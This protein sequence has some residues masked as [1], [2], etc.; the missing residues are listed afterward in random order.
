MNE[1]LTKRQRVL[2][3]KARDL[4]VKEPE[5]YDQERYG[6]GIISCDT[7]AC[8]AGH[9][10]ASEP[11]LREELLLQLEGEDLSGPDGIERIGSA[12]HLIACTALGTPVHPQLFRSGWPIGWLKGAST[13]ASRNQGDDTFVPT[14]ADAVNVIGRTLDG[15]IRNGLRSGIASA[16]R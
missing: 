6:M 14:A 2:L 8:I 4:I 10:V 16:G 13:H 3:T 11:A 9:I 1:A 15:E 12:V 5:G 7:P